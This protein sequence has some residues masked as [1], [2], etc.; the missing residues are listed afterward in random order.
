MND[1]ISSILD[2]LLRKYTEVWLWSVIFGTEVGTM[3]SILSYYNPTYTDWGSLTIIIAILAFLA[4]LCSIFSGYCLYRSAS[5][6]LIP[7]YILMADGSEPDEVDREVFAN[8]LRRAFWYLLIA[9]AFRLSINI[10]ELTLSSLRF[11][12]FSS[13]GGGGALR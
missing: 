10:Y 13:M 4:A 6:Y 1:N 5:D 12:D 3:A 2:K 11:I 7:K 9:I 8:Y